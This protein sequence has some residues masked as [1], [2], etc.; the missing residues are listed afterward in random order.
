[1]DVKKAIK[2]LAEKYPGRIPIGYWIKGDE[3]IINT[4]PLNALK[5]LTAPSQFVVTQ[6]G[7]V[8]GAN[9]MK[10]DLTIESMTKI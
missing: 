6:N 10:Y 1:M 2:L 7:E 9:P 3:Y 8:Y 5:G 4:K